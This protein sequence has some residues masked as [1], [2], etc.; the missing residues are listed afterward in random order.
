M[1]RTERLTLTEPEARHRDALV[2]MLSDREVMAQLVNDP[3]VASAEASLA[4]HQG[5]RALGLGFWAVEHD[6]AVA[7]LCGLKP[8]AADLPIAGELEIGWIF[9]KPYWG[10][11]LAGEAAQA[12]LDWAWA[13][14]PEA[15]VVAI[16]SAV[17]G[18]SRR[19]ME[20]LGMRHLPEMDFEHPLYA[21]GDPMRQTVVYAVDRPA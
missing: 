1:I 2:R 18:G 14:R 11:G 7:G 19:L 4:R 12:A 5:Y 9:D 20:R 21:A 6:G 10:K 16:T 15:R 8:G 17:H 3:T 13:N